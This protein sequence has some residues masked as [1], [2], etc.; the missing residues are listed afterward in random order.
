MGHRRPDVHDRCFVASASVRR[1]PSGRAGPLPRYP[2]RRCVWRC[3]GL[4]LLL[5]A[6][7]TAMVAAGARSDAAACVNRRH[8]ADRLDRAPHVNSVLLRSTC[9]R[10][11]LIV[12]GSARS[13]HLLPA[14]C[15]ARGSAAASRPAR[16]RL[17][18]P[19]ALE[20]ARDD[21]PVPAQHRHVATTTRSRAWS[22]A[23]FWRRGTHPS[24]RNPSHDRRGNARAA[25]LRRVSRFL[26]LQLHRRQG[27]PSPGAECR[28]RSPSAGSSEDRSAGRRESFCRTHRRQPVH[29]PTDLRFVP[30]STRSSSRAGWPSL[31]LSGSRDALSAGPD[32]R[33]S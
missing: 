7:G 4:V 23:W 8:R 11:V 3:V 21:R 19:C 2:A 30:R 14:L 15:A 24:D 5:A 32:S 28:P 12:A 31:A 13:E 20:L 9:G 29:R 10:P 18:R 22:F 6:A 27:G 25:A 26:P 17:R 33:P 16:R 1:C